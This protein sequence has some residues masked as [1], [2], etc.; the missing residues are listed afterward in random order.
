MRTGRSTSCRRTTSRT[1]DLR[2]VLLQMR[3]LMELRRS[4][5][6]HMP[7]MRV[8]QVRRPHQPPRPM[9]GLRPCVEQDGP[10]RGL[11]GMREVHGGRPAEVQ[12]VRPRV[13]HARGPSSEEVPPLP[14]LLMER[15]EDAQVLMP[16]LRACVEEPFRASCQVP[17]LPEQAVGFSCA[18]APMQA[19][20]LQVGPP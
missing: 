19:L 16:S 9:Q 1:Y 6:G 5:T 8:L 11:P 12:P 7:Q 2:P 3:E 17:Q 18:Q 20:R 4:R 14:L 10:G 15:A 13:G